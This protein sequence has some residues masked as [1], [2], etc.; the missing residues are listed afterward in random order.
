MLRWPLDLPNA[1][2]P[3]VMKSWGE[4]PATFAKKA[5]KPIFIGARKKVIVAIGNL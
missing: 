3:R 2:N 4:T 1:V 5:L